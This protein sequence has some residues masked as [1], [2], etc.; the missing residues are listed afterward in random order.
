MLH[1]LDFQNGLALAS[2]VLTLLLIYFDKTGNLKGPML[3]ILL[4]VAALLTLPFALK[5]AWLSEPQGLAKFARGLFAFFIIGS[6]YAAIAVWAIPDSTPS[7]PPPP[8]HPATIIVTPLRTVALHVNYNWEQVPIEIP[9]QT[10]IFVLQLHP[11]IKEWLMPVHN[12]KKKPIRWPYSLRELNQKGVKLPGMAWRCDVTNHGEVA[13]LSTVLAFDVRFYEGSNVSSEDTPA[14]SHV[15]SIAIDPLQPTKTFSFYIV[16][17]SPFMTL[18]H[19]PRNAV[20]QVAGELARRSIPLVGSG[21]TILDILPAE[22]FPPT[23][24]PWTGLPRTPTKGDVN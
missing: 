5:I 4:G 12:G 13:I 22:M 24:I 17:Q 7:P 15:H 19:H 16:N 10:S 21:R 14:F 23:R 2:V 9:A 20:V 1:K 6:V 11:G 3:L 8:P 18:V